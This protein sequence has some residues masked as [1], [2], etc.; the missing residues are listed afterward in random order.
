MV[1]NADSYKNGNS[2]KTL[3]Q[4]SIETPQHTTT[5]PVM[6]LSDP[7]RLLMERADTRSLSA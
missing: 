1:R 7:Q 3:D 4:D 2:G 5:R 6:F